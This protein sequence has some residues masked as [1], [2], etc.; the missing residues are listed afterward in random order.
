MIFKNTTIQKGKYMKAIKFVVMLC[1]MF[2][3]GYAQQ[4]PQV[5]SG[6]IQQFPNFSSK[7]VDARNI[8]V[9]LPKNYQSSKKYC[10]L[11]MQDGQMLFDSAITW[12]H[13]SWH[14]DETV[15]KLLDEGKIKDLI[16]VGIWN[17]EKS[18][19]ADYFPQKPFDALRGNKKEVIYNAARNNGVSVFGNYKIQSDNYLKFV[20]NELKPFIDAHFSTYTNAENTFIMGSSMGGL[21]SVYAICEYPQVFGGA[22][23]LSTHWPGIFQT[24]NNPFPQAMFQY[25]IKN[26]PNPAK[27]KIYFDHG[28]TTL[29]ALYPSLQ[30]EVDEI[31][32]QKGYSNAQWNT[33]IFPGEA[34]SEKAWSKRL[35]IPLLFLLKK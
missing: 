29:D 28:T 11:Y 17:G 30:A 24:E 13:Q 14:V 25:L 10:V 12:N 27:H 35:D 1:C 21:I 3:V 15:S 31:M 7:Y 22:A 33:K 34:H 26:L 8:D 32:K 18:R 5:V 2:S 6:T 20:V 19:H 4:I 23:C 16:V 9:W